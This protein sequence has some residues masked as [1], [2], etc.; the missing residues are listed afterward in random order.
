MSKD[1]FFKETR[2]LKEISMH[3]LHLKSLFPSFSSFV[4]FSALRCL[5]LWNCEAAD[6]FLHDFAVAS[7]GKSQNLVRLAVAEPDSRAFNVDILGTS[8][9]K[10]INSSCNMHSLHLACSCGEDMKEQLMNILFRVRTNLRAFSLHR[11]YRYSPTL[12]IHGFGLE[13]SG[14][15][16][17]SPLLEQLAICG[18]SNSNYEEGL[19][20]FLDEVVVSFTHLPYQNSIEQCMSRTRL[21]IPPR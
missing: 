9:R 2:K 12:D 19:E 5:I 16:Q 1:P 13:F 3:K 15:R 14:I 20:A 4:D 10:I 8:L 6:E 18:G 17:F 21:T 11:T 7:S